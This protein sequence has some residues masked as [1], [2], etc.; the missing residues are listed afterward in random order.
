MN[1][2]N[3]IIPIVSV[4]LGWILNEVSQR[5]K[6]NRNQ[7]QAIAKA[8]SELLEIRDDI[9]VMPKFFERYRKKL[10]L[11]VEQWLKV[12]ASIY[13]FLP[14]NK[15]MKTKYDEA[16]DIISEYDPIL[17]YKLRSK[18]KIGYYLERME[19]ISDSDL[20][21][22]IF[23]NNY[24]KYIINKVKPVLDK[25]IIELSKK[26]SIKTRFKIKRQLEKSIDLDKLDE[27]LDESIDV[28]NETANQLRNN[29]NDNQNFR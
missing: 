11:P 2:Y 4:I 5:F 3:I 28:I 6:R 16:I 20:S 13:E 23:I 27:F 12:R 19:N 17:G 18:D 21:S 22:Q 8:I 29:E 9:L 15:N 1:V 24:K 26:H 25:T 14:K 7:K 10:G